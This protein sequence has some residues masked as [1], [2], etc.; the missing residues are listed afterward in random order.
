MIAHVGG[1]DDGALTAFDADTGEVKWRWTGDGP[2]YASPIVAE[3][4]GIRQVITETQ[5][6]IAGISGMTIGLV[7]GGVLAP[8]SWRLV[9]LI[10]V[11]IGLFATVWGYLKLKELSQPRPSRIDWGSGPADRRRQQ[12]AAPTT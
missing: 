5:N 11:P 8:I 12:P 6:N 4:G 1:H 9:F 10:S 2:A 3:L 7:L